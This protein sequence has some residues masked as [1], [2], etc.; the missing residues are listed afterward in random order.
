M[1]NLYILNTNYKFYLHKIETFLKVN[2]GTLH[3]HVG[4]SL[5]NFNNF[6]LSCVLLYLW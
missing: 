1:Y 2:W 5:S 6:H 3:F 4:N